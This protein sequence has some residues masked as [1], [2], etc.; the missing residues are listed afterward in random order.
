[1]IK[2]INEILIYQKFIKF[3]SV[4]QETMV[5]ILWYDPTH[6]IFLYKPKTKVGFLGFLKDFSFQTTLLIFCVLNL[7]I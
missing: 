5:W 6:T 7:L 3:Y 1:M 2:P 4:V